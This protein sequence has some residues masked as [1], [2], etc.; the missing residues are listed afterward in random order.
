MTLYVLFS[1]IHRADWLTCR[2]KEH[3]RA[4]SQGDFNASVMAE[5]A[6]NMG[7]QIDWSNAGFYIASFTINGSIWSPGITTT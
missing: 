5:H 7:R 4:V 1:V 2:L 3:K 6:V